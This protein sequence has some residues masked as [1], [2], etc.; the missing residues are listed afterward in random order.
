MRNRL[1]AF[2]LGF[3]AMLA[4]TVALANSPGGKGG[5]TPSQAVPQATV[6]Q[7]ISV[8]DLVAVLAIFG[9]VMLLA[10]WALVSRLNR[11][12]C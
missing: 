12:K 8:G 11:K 10:I 6:V 1:S 2:V 5:L 7:G 9:G 4:S 3:T